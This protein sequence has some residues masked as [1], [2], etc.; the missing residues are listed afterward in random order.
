MEMKKAFKIIGIG[1]LSLTLILLVVLLYFYKSDIPKSENHAKY[2]TK[3][4]EYIEIDGNNIHF[5]K[6]GAGLPVLLIHGSF[7]S[8]HTW[9]IWQKQLQNDFTTIA[10]D[11]PGHGL[12]GP[13]QKEKYDTDYYANLLWKLIDKLNYDSIAIAGNSM[14]GQVAYKMALQKPEQV[15]KLIL[16]N[17]SGARLQADSVDFKDQNNFSVFDL[18]NHPVFSKLMTSITPK[19]LF[20]MSLKQVYFDHSKITKERIQMYYDLMLHKGNRK[21]TLKRFNQRSPSEFEKLETLS[22]PTLILWGEHDSWIPV[23][24]ALRFDSIL[25][26]NKLKVYSDAGHVPMEEIPVKTAK[27]ALGFLKD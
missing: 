10:I 25:P 7:S 9:E 27:D 5:R 17:S 20:E 22:C 13:N 4:S 1:F 15:K 16:I 21:A 26:N 8:L 12:T 6:M 2:F 23:S 11:L 18:I 24:H 19:F 3:E 14:G